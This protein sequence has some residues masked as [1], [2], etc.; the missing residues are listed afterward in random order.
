MVVDEQEF[1]TFIA[2]IKHYV[3]CT[4]PKEGQDEEE[5]LIV[6]NKILNKVLEYIILLEKQPKD[7]KWK[8]LSLTIN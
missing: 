3:N 4:S 6:E 8:Q 2:N 7:S 1:R 5:F